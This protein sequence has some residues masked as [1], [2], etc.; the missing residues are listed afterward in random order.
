MDSVPAVLLITA[1]QPMV[2]PVSSVLSAIVF[3]VKPAIFAPFARLVTVWSQV[4][5][6]SATF[7]TVCSA[8][9]QMSAV[10]VLVTLCLQAQ[11][12]FVRFAST[13]V[14]LA[15]ATAMVLAFVSPVSILTV[16]TPTIMDSA[17]LVL[18]IDAPTATILRSASATLVFL[19]TLPQE[20]S[21][22]TPAL[23]RN[24]KHAVQPILASAAAVFLDIMLIRTLLSARS[25]L[26]LQDVW[27]VWPISPL[28]AS[29]APMDSI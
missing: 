23:N 15:V 2:M 20:V 5:V 12:L 6:L 4:H 18:I 16:P 8:P 1:S 26:T 21:A 25:A 27:S 10:H 17:I 29:L 14:P 13:L 9:Q 7:P 28:S 22:P 19:D 3:L 24:V 11:D